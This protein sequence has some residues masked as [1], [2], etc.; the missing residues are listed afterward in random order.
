VLVAPQWIERVSWHEAKVFVALAREAVARAPEYDASA[1]PS[2][3]L[4]AKLFDY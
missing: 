4:E 2:R 1:P 3:E